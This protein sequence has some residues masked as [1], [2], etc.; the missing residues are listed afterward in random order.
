MTGTWMQVMAQ[1]YV[2]TTLTHSALM[3]G[4]VNMA[5]GLPSLLLSMHGGAVAD[6]HDKRMILLASQVVQFALAIVM[7]YLV[8]IQVLRI[9]HVIVISLAQGIVTAFEMPAANAIVPE[10][11][12]KDQIQAAL[13]LDRTVFHATRLIGPAAAGFAIGHWGTATAF[14]ANALSFV[15]LTIAL[16]TLPPRATGTP[17]EEEQR[18]GGMKAGLDY[19]RSDGPTMAM[20]GLIALTT[21]LVFPAMT[22][23]M[24]LYASDILLLPAE[25]MGTLMSVSAIG[26]LLGSVGLL[27]VQRGHRFVAMTA[28]ALGI[29]LALTGMSAARTLVQG[30]VSLVLLTVSISMTI[31]LANTVVQERAPGP[32]RGRVSAIAGL[33][34]FGLGPIA[35][36]VLTGLSDA[37]GMR[38]ALAVCAGLFVVGAL[39]LMAGPGRRAVTPES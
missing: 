27:K 13:A 29:G 16:L 10:M 5:S 24:P 14:F 25:G 33:A 18:G 4:V 23:I 17:E 34:F 8:L 26:S 3:L 15:P 32:L 39:T 22:V 35:G 9:E 36:L 21:F 31:G 7:G 20:I 30:G 12:E 11:V 1:G 2:M 19:V 28:G 6:K 38:T 37:I